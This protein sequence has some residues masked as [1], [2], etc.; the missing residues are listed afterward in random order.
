MAEG[1]VP[2]PEGLEGDEKETVE[3]ILEYLS[4]PYMSSTGECIELANL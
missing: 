2:R 4:V 3:T 1:K